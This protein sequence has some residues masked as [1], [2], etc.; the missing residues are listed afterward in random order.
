M[1][2]R[3]VFPLC[4]DRAKVGSLASLTWQKLSG[5]FCGAVNFVIGQSRGIVFLVLLLFERLGANIKIM[6]C[7]TDKSNPKGKG[8]K[9]KI[10]IERGTGKS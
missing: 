8:G 6:T 9:E 4:R 2:P 7:L 10:Q 5:L 1:G 3:A